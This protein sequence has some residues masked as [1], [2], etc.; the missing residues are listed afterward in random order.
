MCA[1]NWNTECVMLKRAWVSLRTRGR[2]AL[3]PAH[4]A[5]AL[6]LAVANLANWALA[7]YG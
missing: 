5:R 6:L 1:I 7:A 3:R 2:R 4:S